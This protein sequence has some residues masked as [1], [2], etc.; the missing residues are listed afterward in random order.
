MCFLV[1]PD[2]SPTRVIPAICVFGSLARVM[3]VRNSWV[4]M[5]LGEVHQFGYILS[6]ENF[7]FFTKAAIRNSSLCFPCDKEESS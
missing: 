7:Q 5:A 4:I 3:E 2:K 1:N 6:Q